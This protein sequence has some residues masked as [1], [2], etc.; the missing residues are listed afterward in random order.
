VTQETELARDA[1]SGRGVWLTAAGYVLRVPGMNEDV[2][3]WLPAVP[4]D[5]VTL[6]A[7][8]KWGMTPV[9]PEG[10]A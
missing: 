4:R 1:D 5:R 9:T 7:V 10:Q 8:T 3:L 6:I 2:F